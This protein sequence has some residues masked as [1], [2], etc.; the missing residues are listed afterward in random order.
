MVKSQNHVA[1]NTPTTETFALKFVNC[2]KTTHALLPEKMASMNVA[3]DSNA[4]QSTH[5]SHSETLVNT[6]PHT[7]H[8]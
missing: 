3:S 2:K 1:I 8:M 6:Q 4:F 7:C 5:Q